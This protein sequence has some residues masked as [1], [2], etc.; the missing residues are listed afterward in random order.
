MSIGNSRSTVDRQK[1]TVFQCSE[2]CWVTHSTLPSSRYFRSDR[3]DKIICKS[4]FSALRIAN[5]QGRFLISPGPSFWDMGSNPQNLIVVLSPMLTWHLD[6]KECRE[7]SI[8]RSSCFD[9]CQQKSCNRPESAKIGS[10][11]LSCCEQPTGKKEKME[12]R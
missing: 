8:L 10:F 11:F 7:I 5:N 12:P 6:L 4:A 9:D 2:L 1:G 3:E